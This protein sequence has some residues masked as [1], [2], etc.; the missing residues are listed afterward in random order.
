MLPGVCHNRLLTSPHETDDFDDVARPQMPR[1]MVIA[2]YQLTVDL[3]GN[4]PRVCLEPPEQLS[5]R[6][7]LFDDE[8]FAVDSEFDIRRWLRLHSPSE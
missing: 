7:R 2:R 1:R 5:Q 3:D 6:Q 4:P 8:S